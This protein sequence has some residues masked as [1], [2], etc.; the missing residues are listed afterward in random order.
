MK[1]F[2]NLYDTIKQE[3]NDALPDGFKEEITKLMNSIDEES[4]KY[5]D[6]PRAIFDGEIFSLNRSEDA[7]SDTFIISAV[8]MASYY[9][10]YKI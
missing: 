5:I 2:V 10:R 1:E 3:G 6:H 8:S 9:K 4:R 7:M